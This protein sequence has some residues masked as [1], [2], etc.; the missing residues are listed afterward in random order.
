MSHASRRQ[1][2]HECVDVLPD[3]YTNALVA[4]LGQQVLEHGPANMEVA[5]G[6]VQVTGRNVTIKYRP[7]AR[8]YRHLDEEVRQEFLRV[9]YI[10]RCGR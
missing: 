1:R 10:Q 5:Q 9:R 2:V 3:G 8:V 7:A 6:Q 4:N